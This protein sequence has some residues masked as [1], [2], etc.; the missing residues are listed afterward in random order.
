MKNY[1][2]IEQKIVEL[3]QEIERLKKHEDYYIPKGFS[4]VN[5]LKSLDDKT[6]LAA[7]FDWNDTPQ[8]NQYWGD[9]C[10]GITELSNKDIIQIQKWVILALQRGQS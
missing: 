8:G 7:S 6:W 1:Q 2:E 3:Q 9:R 5:A 10:Y 4:I